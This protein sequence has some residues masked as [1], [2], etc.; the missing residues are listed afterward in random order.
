VYGYAC[1]HAAKPKHSP[2]CS[3]QRLNV[4][5]G[6]ADQ[7]PE[8]GA[9]VEECEGEEEEEEDVRASSAI[10]AGGQAI[11]EVDVRCGLDPG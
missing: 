2:A 5:N 9:E 11:V 10:V 6:H 3:Q 4:Q 7:A 1:S 8:E